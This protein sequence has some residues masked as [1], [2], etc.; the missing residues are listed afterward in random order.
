MDVAIFVFVLCHNAF[1]LLPTFN[2]HSSAVNLSNEHST[3]V[4][5]INVILSVDKVVPAI[6]TWRW[7]V[8]CSIELGSTLL[9]D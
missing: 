8:P 1:P 6:A 9:D 2:L 3:K 5:G 7:T 4:S